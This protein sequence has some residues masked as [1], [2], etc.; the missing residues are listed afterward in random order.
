MLWLRPEGCSV[1]GRFSSGTF[2]VGGLG[3][4]LCFGGDVSYS[5]FVESFGF[6]AAGG[7]VG[8]IGPFVGC[9]KGRIRSMGRTGLLVDNR[10]QEREA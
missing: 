3:G 8:S 6:L 7:M 2:L 1:L 9:M 5:S 4:G 10:L